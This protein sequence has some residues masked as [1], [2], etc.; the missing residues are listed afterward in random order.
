MTVS[1]YYIGDIV[2]YGTRNEHNVKSIKDNSINFKTLRS[3]KRWISISI[4]STK[5]LGYWNLCKWLGGNFEEV[6]IRWDIELTALQVSLSYL[7]IRRLIRVNE[8][9]VGGRWICSR[10]GDYDNVWKSQITWIMI[11]RLPT[12]NMHLFHVIMILRY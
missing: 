12:P 10:V 1:T 9:G 8:R 6:E 5:S 7:N 2:I 4:H 3:K 11:L